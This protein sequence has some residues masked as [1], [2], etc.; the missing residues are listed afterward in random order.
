MDILKKLTTK[1]VLATM[2]AE[3][4]KARHEIN[5]A[6]KDIIKANGRIGFVLAL[7]T[8]LQHRDTGE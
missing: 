3:S 8:E 7:V 2:T 6:K 1:E 5:C 4:A